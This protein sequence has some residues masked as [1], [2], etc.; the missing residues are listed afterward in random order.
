VV[1]EPLTNCKV[2]SVVLCVLRD[3]EST[4]LQH[5]TWIPELIIFMFLLNK[6]NNT[7]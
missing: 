4:L 1:F 5:H 6:F 2:E 3:T 7:P